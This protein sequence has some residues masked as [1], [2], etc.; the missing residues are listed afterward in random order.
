MTRNKPNSALDKVVLKYRKAGVDV[1]ALG[2]N[3]ASADIVEGL[4]APADRT[5]GR[6]RLAPLI[7][8]KVAEPP[9]M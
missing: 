9:D 6:E 3:K 2:S 5:A 8:S 4:P 7:A 1:E